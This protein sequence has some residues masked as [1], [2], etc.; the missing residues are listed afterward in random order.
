MNISLFLK[1][2][3]YRSFEQVTIKWERIIW[4]LKA[5]WLADNSLIQSSDDDNSKPFKWIAWDDLKIE[6]VSKGHSVIFISFN[7]MDYSHG[8]LQSKILEWVAFVFSRDLP[9]LGFEFRSPALQADS[10]PAE[11][12]RKPQTNI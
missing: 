4:D 8:L 10:L 9:D 2:S 1:Q 11:P 7:P 5:S 3:S 6:W 12:Q